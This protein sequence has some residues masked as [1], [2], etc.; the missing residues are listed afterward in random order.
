MNKM[1][2]CYMLVNADDPFH[3]T[4]ILIYKYHI[5]THTHTHVHTHSQKSLTSLT[6]VVYNNQSV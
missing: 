3:A 1:S 4:K 2:K 6:A 5:H